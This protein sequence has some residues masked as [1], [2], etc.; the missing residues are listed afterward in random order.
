[1]ALG[2]MALPA[3]RCADDAAA[4]RALQHAYESGREEHVRMFSVMALA[5]IGGEGNRA[6]LLQAYVR[7]NKTMEKPWLAVAL[8]VHAA[9]SA[10]RGEVDEGI[11][12]LLL[13]ELEAASHEDMK[14]PLVIAVGLTRYRLAAPT[15]LAMLQAHSENERIAGYLCT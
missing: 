1:I 14:T 9:A 6:W 11:A 4:S 15:V 8:G 3:E 5:R 10:D 12:K 2:A 7:G 13:A